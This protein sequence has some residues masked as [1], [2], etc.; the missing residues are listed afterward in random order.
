MS[1]G[2]FKKTPSHEDELSRYSLSYAV[3]HT[4]KIVANEIL[5]FRQ[6]I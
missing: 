3:I 1:W 2:L 6:R 5:N 4:S